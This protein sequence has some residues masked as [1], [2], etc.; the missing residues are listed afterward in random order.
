M[1]G[2]QANRHKKILFSKYA[3]NLLKDFTEGFYSVFL[4]PNFKHIGSNAFL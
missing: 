2:I 3:G 4:V 1:K